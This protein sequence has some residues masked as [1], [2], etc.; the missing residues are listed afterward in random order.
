M[1]VAG[2][3]ARVVGETGSTVGE[4]E[5]ILNGRQGLRRARDATDWG[6]SWTSCGGITARMYVG[7]YV[8]RGTV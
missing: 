1:R 8:G 6:S 3:A 2:G 5:V 4:G 7:M